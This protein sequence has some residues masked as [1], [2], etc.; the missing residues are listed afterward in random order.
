MNDQERITDFLSSEKKMSA[1]Y[2]TFASECVNVPLRDEFLRLFGQSHHTQT[3]LF[4]TAQSKG[5]YQ[6]E[7][8]PESKITQAYQKYSTQQPN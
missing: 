1:N 3:E 8:A 4:Q 7:Q 2:D 5:W 6:P